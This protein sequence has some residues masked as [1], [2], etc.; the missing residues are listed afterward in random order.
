MPGGRGP[1]RNHAGRP[2]PFRGPFCGSP[3]PAA[4]PASIS[5][6]SSLQFQQFV[7]RGTAAEAGAPAFDAPGTFLEGDVAPFGRDRARW[8]S[9][10]RRR[11]SSHVAH[12]ELADRAHQPLR[13]DAVQRG[14]KVI[15]LDA[16]VQEA[17]EHIY[18]VVGVDGGEDQ[19]AGDCGLDGDLGGFGVADLADDD[20]VRILPQDERRPR[21]ELLPFFSLTGIWVM[22]RI[23]TRRV[24]DGDDLAF[25]ELLSSSTA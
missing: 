23:W 3:S 24:F 14:D 19:V 10:V 17:A 13:Q 15:R 22:P 1:A 18:H 6:I 9:A 16:H 2:C 8:L 7:D 5:R 12:A 11:C 20:L 21:G 25:L 4:W